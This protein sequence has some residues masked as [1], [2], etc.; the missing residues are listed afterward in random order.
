MK[1][2]IIEWCKTRV[3]CIAIISYIAIVMCGIYLL[4]NGT[5][6]GFIY[7]GLWIL[8]VAVTTITLH[9]IW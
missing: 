5:L 9:K 6:K 7:I 3:I 8:F 1:R 2:F 4:D